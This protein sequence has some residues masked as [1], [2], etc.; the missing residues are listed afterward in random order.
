MERSRDRP[1]PEARSR[2]GDQRHQVDTRRLDRGHQAESEGRHGRHRRRES[3]HPVVERE[4]QENRAAGRPG[5]RRE[6]VQQTKRAIRQREP[7]ASAGDGQKRALDE[8]QP[9]DAAPAGPEG[10]TRGELALPRAGAGEQEARDIRAGDEQHDGHD[11]HLHQHERP[12]ETREQRMGAAGAAEHEASIRIALRI[13]LEHSPRQESKLGRRGIPRDLRFQSAGQHDARRV[14]TGALGLA[15]AS[16]PGRQPDIGID[17]GKRADEPPRRDAHDRECRVVDGQGPTDDGRIGAE[18][19]APEP[20][21]HDDD[22]GRVGP[23]FERTEIAAQ[24]RRHAQQR[25][26]PGGHELRGGRLLPFRTG[27]GNR[28]N[29]VPHH[30]GKRRGVVAQV[31]VLLECRRAE[32]LIVAHRAADAD[33]IALAVAADRS[34]QHGVEHAEHR[35]VHRNGEGQRRDGGQGQGRR[36]NE[37]AERVAEVGWHPITL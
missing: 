18:V 14:A 6:S 12:D 17:T 22:G 15:D 37:H 27:H 16:K 20:I 33:E 29:L 26:V 23:I 1:R 10:Q 11:R 28:S 34:Q 35:G 7:D 21:A 25:E 4:V 19:T 3:E 5:D 31:F 9:D 30:A 8:Q 32:R 24:A 13:L 2:I 36:S